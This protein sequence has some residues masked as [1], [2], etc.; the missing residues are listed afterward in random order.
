MAT[1]RRIGVNPVANEQTLAAARVGDPAARWK[2]LEACRQYLRLVVGKNRW[3][4]KAGGPATSDLVQDTILEGW[5][6]FG[7]FEGRTEGQL[8]A[9]LRVIAVHALFKARQRRALA[10]LESRGGDGAIPGSVTPPSVVFQREASN[11]AIDAAL[12]ALPEHYREVIHW[13]VWDGL[14]FAQIGSRLGISDDCAQKLYGRAIARLRD[15][16]G[17]GH[18]P[19]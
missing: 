13:R 2:A 4:N 18:E 6:G 1:V 14:P 7:R 17:P 19:G 9:W 5:R 8:R 12:E 15:E 16:L 3:S 10:A 11:A